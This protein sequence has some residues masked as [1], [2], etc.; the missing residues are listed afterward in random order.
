[1]SP[2]QRTNTA[3][4]NFSGC[5]W[6]P[7]PGAEN[8]GFYR[9]R[10]TEYEIPG[11]SGA[12]QFSLVQVFSSACR[13]LLLQYRFQNQTTNAQTQPLVADMDQIVSMY[14]GS[15]ENVPHDLWPVTGAD[16][17]GRLLVLSHFRYD[18]SRVECVNPP[19]P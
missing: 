1:E 11:S 3:T 5:S 16:S 8:D 10:L 13:T 18:L 7:V 12:D 15:P 14:D 17:E 2:A 4:R 9:L 19:S 6:P